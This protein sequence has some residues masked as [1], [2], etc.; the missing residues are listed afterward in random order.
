[1]S[2]LTHATPVSGHGT[3]VNLF[4]GLKEIQFSSESHLGND[5]LEKALHKAAGHSPIFS[6]YRCFTTTPTPAADLILMGHSQEGMETSSTFSSV[7]LNGWL[8]EDMAAIEEL[9]IASGMVPEVFN[10][11]DYIQTHNDEH[12]HNWDHPTVPDSEL[13]QFESWFKYTGKN[14]WMD[15]VPEEVAKQLDQWE[16]EH[17]WDKANPD[18]HPVADEWALSLN[19]ALELESN[20]LWADRSEFEGE[21]TPVNTRIYSWGPKFAIGITRWGTCFIPK[22]MMEAAR[23]KMD[24]EGCAL[25]TMRPAQGRHPFRA[26]WINDQ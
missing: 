9:A 12:H 26:T 21:G 7:G 6:E 17:N 22:S 19:R 13:D 5:E 18:F 14:Q 4:G 16:A 10:D 11:K 25:I 20:Q 8:E 15:D 1:M 3:Y 24:D 23:A 2:S